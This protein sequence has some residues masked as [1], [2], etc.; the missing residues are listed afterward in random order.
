[1]KKKLLFQDKFFT[2]TIS[3]MHLD[4]VDIIFQDL[5]LEVALTFTTSLLLVLLGVSL[6]NLCFALRH[7]F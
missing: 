5:V 6:F 4:L 1:M 2:T 3:H 7:V